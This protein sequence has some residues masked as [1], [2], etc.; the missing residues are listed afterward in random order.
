MNE[1]LKRQSTASHE[2]LVR[3]WLSEF[4]SLPKPSRSSYAA[5]IKNRNHLI[6]SFHFCFVSLNDPNLSC[7]IQP[8]CHQLFEF[9]KSG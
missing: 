7:L 4:K 5:K 3:D 8:I 2:Q 9:Y 6:K 1:K